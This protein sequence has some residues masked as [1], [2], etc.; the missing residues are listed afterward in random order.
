MS[1]ARFRVLG[2]LFDR[3][4][5]D[6]VAE[7]EEEG[8]NIEGENLDDEAAVKSD[9]SLMPV[10]CGSIAGAGVALED[11]IREGTMPESEK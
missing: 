3:G 5:G 1:I 8:E 6:G 11:E 9:A 10:L 2:P 4:S 7:E